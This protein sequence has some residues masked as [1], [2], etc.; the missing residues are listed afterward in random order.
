MASPSSTGRRPSRRR[1]VLGGEPIARGA[2]RGVAHRAAVSTMRTV[3][4]LVVRHPSAR[5]APAGGIDRPACPQ[6]SAEAALDRPRNTDAVRVERGLPALGERRDARA[7]AVGDDR[8]HT[9]PRRRPAA[10]A[11]VS[12][13]APIRRPCERRPARTARTIDCDCRWAWGSGV[14]T[15][16]R[17]AVT[18]RSRSRQKPRGPCPVKR[19]GRAS[20]A[21]RRFVT[22]V[23]DPVPATTGAGGGGGRGGGGG[24]G[25]GRPPPAAPPPLCVSRRGARCVPI[26]RR[27]HA[28]EG[29][30]HRQQR[31]RADDPPTTT[32]VASG[33]W[34]CEPMPR[35]RLPRRAGLP[36]VRRAPSRSCRRAPRRPHRRAGPLHGRDR[37][38]GGQHPALPRSRA[39]SRPGRVAGLSGPPCRVRGFGL[40]GA[41]RFACC[42]EALPGRSSDL[43]SGRGIAVR[44]GFADLAGDAPDPLSVEPGKTSRSRCAE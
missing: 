2:I 43:P 10:R 9:A 41:E 18:G 11:T 8:L 20:P 6:R 24:A 37:G 7:C 29:R 12:R 44:C 15:V 14:L 34:T 19:S 13:G 36:A 30:D 33:C 23:R 32:T 40:R 39:V 28:P 16:T 22:P 26:R 38:R 35:Q 4:H 5:Q 25:G 21:A 42:G 31:H 1:G 3:R 17:G 27:E